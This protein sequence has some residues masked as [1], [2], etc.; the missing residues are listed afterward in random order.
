M[1]LP[2]VDRLAQYEVRG[3]LG[4]GGMGEVY[5]VSELRLNHEIAIKEVLEHLT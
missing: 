4:A 5:R 3:F 2:V 1:P